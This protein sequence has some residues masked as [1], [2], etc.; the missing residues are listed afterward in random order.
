[1][2]LFPAQILSEQLQFAATCTSPSSPEDEADRESDD[3]GREAFCVRDLDP[4]KVGRQYNPLNAD[5]DD[6]NSEKARREQAASGAQNFYDAYSSFA[7]QQEWLNSSH[8]FGGVSMTGAEIS[9]LADRLRKDPKYLAAIKDGLAQ[10]GFKTPEQQEAALNDFFFYER[11]AGRSPQERA[12][13]GV[14][15]E[16]LDRAK[17]SAGTKAVVQTHKELIGI[18][19]EVGTRVEGR[20]EKSDV[21][22]SAIEDKAY[23][24]FAEVGKDATLPKQLPERSADVANSDPKAEAVKP[25]A[26][27]AAR[28]GEV[29]PAVVRPVAFKPDF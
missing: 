10:R 18:T 22:A 3:F 2:A 8:D 4:Y 17:N 27:E 5:P 28:V 26:A 23:E 15:D 1:M 21:V 29:E 19:P 6:P 16:A 25:D 7:Y 9:G 20:L 13:A 12:Q 24:A 14:T 11:W